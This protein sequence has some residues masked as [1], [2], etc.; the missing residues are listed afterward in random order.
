MF[1]DG[2]EKALGCGHVRCRRVEAAEARVGELERENADL[3]QGIVTVPRCRQCQDTQR[4]ADRLAETVRIYVVEDR[5]FAREGVVEAL[6]AYEAE[7]PTPT[8]THFACPQRHLDYKDEA[9]AK[10]ALADRLAE[11]GAQRDGGS[12]DAACLRDQDTR[13]RPCRCGH[14]EWTKALA[15]YHSDSPPQAVHP[16]TERL[17]WL[18]GNMGIITTHWDDDRLDSFM[19]EAGGVVADRKTLREAIDAAREGESD[20]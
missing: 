6:A 19:V 11:A 9:R 3:R 10:L 18:E 8:A 1:L 12:C 15:A 17:D 4:C 5:P 13:E 7:E 14:V 16:D 20:G 2:F